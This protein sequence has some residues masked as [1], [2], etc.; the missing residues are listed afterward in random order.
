MGIRLFRW[1]LT[2]GTLLGAAIS[3]VLMPTGLTL[4]WA[5][6][7]FLVGGVGA[8]IGAVVGLL[9]CAGAVVA[10][11]IL[12]TQCRGASLRSRSLIAGVGALVATLL[13]VALVLGPAVWAEG[14]PDVAFAIVVGIGIPAVAC[15]IAAPVYHRL[16][17]EDLKLIKPDG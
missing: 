9:A 12:S 16:A 2:I 13:P 7:T 15:A 8:V 6:L 1:A 11:E 3:F 5:S 14:G 10:T 4:E 17:T